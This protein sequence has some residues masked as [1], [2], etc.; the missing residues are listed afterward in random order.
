MFQITFRWIKKLTQSDTATSELSEAN[1]SYPHFA[2]SIPAYLPSML[3]VD[4]T[5]FEVFCIKWLYNSILI[6]IEIVNT[7]SFTC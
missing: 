5:V 4:S 7:K 1:I 6:F 3:E 2:G